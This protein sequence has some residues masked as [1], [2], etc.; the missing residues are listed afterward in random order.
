MRGR[1]L[2]G[3]QITYLFRVAYYS[4][5]IYNLP[6]RVPYYSVFCISPE[7]GRFF[8]VTGLGLQGLE[9]RLQA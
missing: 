9:L 5:F 3:P 1:G 8:G 4:Y 6:F 2:P 7:T